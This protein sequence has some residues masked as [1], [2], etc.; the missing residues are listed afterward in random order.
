MKD[1]IERVK[2]GE[3]IEIT[4]NGE[5]VAAMLHPSKLK[6]RIRTPNTVAAEKLMAEMRRMKDE[7]LP[8]FGEGMSL[9][10]AEEMIQ[11]IRAERDAWN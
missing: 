5:V 1:V 2:R 6:V 9:E 7:P 10:R 8:E 11:K 3:E 4:Q